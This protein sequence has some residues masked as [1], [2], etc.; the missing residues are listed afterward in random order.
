MRT[1]ASFFCL[2]FALTLVSVSCGKQVPVP[3]APEDVTGPLKIVFLTDTHYGSSAN[4]KNMAMLVE[5][6]NRQEGVDFVLV[7]GDIADHGTDTQLAGAKAVLDKLKVPYWVVSGNHDSKWSESGGST[8]IKT[9]G[10]ER[11][12]FEAKGYRFLGCA[13]GP[14]QRMALGLVANEHMEWLRSLTKG[15]PVIFLNHYPLDSGMSN[16]FDVRREI[17][18]LDARLVIGGHTHSDKKY[19]YDGLP[20]FTARTAQVR[21]DFAAY[22][23]I[24]IDEG[25]VTVCDRLVNESSAE[26]TEPWY[27][28][29]LKPVADALL[30]DSDG[31]PENYPWM[32]YS[33]NASWPQVRVRWSL[34]ET[35]NIGSGF[36]VADGT[37]W[38][39]TTSGKVCAL[40]TADGSV[41]WTKTFDGKIWATPALGSGTLVFTT[42][43]GTVY[44]MD[45]ESGAGIWEYPGSSKVASPA[46]YGDAVYVGSSDGAFRALNLSDGKLKWRCTG[47]AGFCDATPYVDKSQVVAGAWGGGLYSM[48]AASGKLQWKWTGPT[49]Y[50]LAPGACPPLKTGNK[51][52]VASPDRNTY[53]VDAGK[54]TIVYS[55][56]GG[57]ES[58]AMS[59]DGAVLYVKNIET[60]AFAMKT[61]DGSK[62]WEVETGLGKDIGSSA[63]CAV[64][65]LVLIPSDKGYILALDAATG[66]IRWKHK[67]GLGLVNPLSAWVESN[68]IIVLASTEEGRI[69]LL[70]VTK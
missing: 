50:L 66:D 6:I 61:S 18:R 29:D 63:L 13:S 26:T 57:R 9:F 11:F 47:I 67:V 58:I 54:G 49:S 4:N 25:V 22:S 43:N 56:E 7:G 41:R 70:E 19:D 31:L 21:N 34:Q 8:F 14:D 69:E 16:W 28:A 35:A 23:I 62:L 36:A 17:I 2:F 27:R 51:I 46:I 68:H 39:T 55:V 20:G 53:C 3:V 1:R 32:K 59:A 60:T 40:S 33:D 52:F 37:A 65:D 12:E 15:K 42:S 64:G 5:D 45:A 30:Y 48:D 44:A 10:Y 24:D 38:Y